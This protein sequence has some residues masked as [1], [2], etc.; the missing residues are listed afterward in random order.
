MALKFGTKLGTLRPSHRRLWPRRSRK[1]RANDTRLDRCVAIN[2]IHSNLSCTPELKNR[3][4]RE[5]RVL[6]SLSHPHICALHD[7]GINGQ[8]EFLVMELLDGETLLARLRKGPLPVSAVVRLGIELADALAAAHRLGVI[9]RDLKP[10]NIMLTA[11]GAKLNFGLAKSE[12]SK[13]R[14]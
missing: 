12:H 14:Y 5:A 1:G 2:V 13:P 3:F 8:L 6:S 9:H 4:E 10:S 7:V 11:N